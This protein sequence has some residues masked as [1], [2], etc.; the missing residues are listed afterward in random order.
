MPPGPT[1]NR[2]HPLR[3]ES[4]RFAAEVAQ[5]SS[6]RTVASSSLPVWVQ[7]QIGVRCSAWLGVDVAPRQKVE[8]QSLRALKT[9]THS[10]RSTRTNMQPV[11]E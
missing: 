8:Q 11:S 2:N 3:Y 4:S 10:G 7:R 6:A 1:I 5:I 9:S